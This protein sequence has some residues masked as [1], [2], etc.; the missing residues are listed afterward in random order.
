MHCEKFEARLMDLLDARERPE[1]DAALVSHAES[2][3]NCRDLLA[4]QEQLFAGLEL[5]EP[6]AMSAD[7]SSRV[8][9]AT[10]QNTTAEEPLVATLVRRKSATLWWALSAVVAASLL[11]V[12]YP[13]AN[14]I[15]GGVAKVPVDA[16]P[17]LESAQPV[18]PPNTEPEMNFV[19]SPLV[20]PLPL[21]TP[22]PEPKLPMEMTAERLAAEGEEIFRTI[23]ETPMDESVERI[24]GFRPIANSFGLA[25]GA[26]RKTLPGMKE[27]NPSTMNDPKQPVRPNKPQAEFFPGPGVEGIA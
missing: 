14:W 8:V 15:H 22:A 27:A 1:S 3:E 11:I 10:L 16:Q 4:A 13:V 5:W 7:F 6:P 23:Q 12:A 19:Q 25:I 20:P 17:K 9:A 21:V 18:P 24:P 26:A 2:C